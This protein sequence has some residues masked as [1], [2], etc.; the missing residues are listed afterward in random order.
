V[1][2]QIAMLDPIS[3]N[4]RSKFQQRFYRINLSISGSAMMNSL[5]LPMVIIGVKRRSLR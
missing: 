5:T 2:F 4:R 3:L 1:S